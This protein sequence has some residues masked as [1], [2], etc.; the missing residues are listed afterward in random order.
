ML[1]LDLCD[2]WRIRNPEA[3]RFTWSGKTQGRS[4]SPNITM[5]RR[6]DYFF[7]SDELQ[8]YVEELNRY[9]SDSV[10]RSLRGDFAYK[11]LARR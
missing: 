10:H 5:Y 8:P 3:K 11:I 2:K 9:Y 6:L 1:D 4:S 7:I